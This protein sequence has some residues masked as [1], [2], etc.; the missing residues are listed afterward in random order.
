ML[1]SAVVKRASGSRST[2]SKGGRKNGSKRRSRCTRA[3]DV[4]HSQFRNAEPVLAFGWGRLVLE[5]GLERHRRFP[6]VRFAPNYGGE[7]ARF[8]NGKKVYSKAA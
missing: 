1:I 2:A 8:V 4:P 5:S 3:V 6:R 7:A